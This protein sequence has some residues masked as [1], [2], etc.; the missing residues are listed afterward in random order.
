MIYRRHGRMQVLPNIDR[1]PTGPAGH[2]VVAGLKRLLRKLMLAGCACLA[3]LAPIAPAAETPAPAVNLRQPVLRLPPTARAPVIDGK[4]GEAEWAGAW[5]MEG[6]VGSA[7][8]N[9]EQRKAWAYIAYDREHLYLAIRSATRPGGK[10]HIWEHDPDEALLNMDGV[11][12][13]V[14]APYDPAQPPIDRYQIWFDP[15]GTQWAL[16]HRYGAGFNVREKLNRASSIH[17]D[18]WDIELAFPWRLLG[19]KPEDIKDGRHVLVRPCRNWCGPFLYTSWGGSGGFY[20]MDNMIRVILDSSAPLVRVPSLGDLFAGKAEVKIDV[21][22]ST[23]APVAVKANLVIG[24]YQAAV[25]PAA[26]GAPIASDSRELAVAPGKTRSVTASASF[27]P[28][29][30]LAAKEQH[31]QLRSSYYSVQLDVTRAADGAVLFSRFLKVPGKRDVLW[32]ALPVRD[33]KL[34]GGYYPYFGKV[35]ASLNLGDDPRAKSVTRAVVAVSATNEPGKTLATGQMTAFPY[36]KGETILDVGTLSAGEYVIRADVFARDQ[37]LDFAK[38]LERVFARQSMPWENTQC[39]ITDKVYPPFTPIAVKGSTVSCV[40][41]DHVVGGLGFWNQVVA[42]GE[43]ILAAP[44]GLEG[45][46]NGKKLEWNAPAAPRFIRQAGH[47]TVLEGEASCAALTAKTR[48]LWEYDGMMKVELDLVPAGDGQVDEL[49]LVIP[50]KASVATLMHSTTATRSNPSMEIPAGKG[51]VWDSRRMVQTV[52]KGTFTP[53]IWIGGVERGVCWFADNDRG[54]ITDDRQAAVELQRAGD[55]VNLRVRLINR[56]GVV[57]GPRHIV[58]GLMATPVKPTP[59]ESRAW[60]ND[61]AAARN[62]V[63]HLPSWRFAGF[64]NRE[65]L[66]PLG[67]DFSIFAYFARHQGTGKRPADADA[68]LR[69]WMLRHVKEPERGGLLRDLASG[70]NR[71]VNSDEIV[72]YTNPA[73]EDGSTPQGRQFVNEWRGGINSM[74][75]NFVRSY[76][77]YAAW[78]Y[79]QMLAP[80][81]KCGVYHDNTFPVASTDVIAGSAYVREDGRVQAGWNIFG[82]REFYKRLF[83]AGWQRMGRMPLIYPHTTNGMTIP[84]FSFATIHLALEWEQ[85][86]LRTF[87]EKFKFPLLRTEVM[88]RQA[89]LVPRVLC[90]MEGGGDA[91]TQGY[92]YRTREG[93]LLLHDCYPRGFGPYLGDVVRQLIPLGFHKPSCEFVGYWDKPAQVKTSEGTE[94]SLLKMEKGL[95][96]VVVDTTGKDGVRQVSFDP[97]ALGGQVTDIR[98]FEAD[99]LVRLRADPAV[100]RVYAREYKSYGARWVYFHADRG[101]RKTAANT[102]EFDLRK[103]DYCLLFVPSADAGE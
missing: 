50:V 58:F 32:Q 13:W 101:F 74:G 86:S 2:P 73:L 81:L 95:L 21:A 68:F 12:F 59:S 67:G 92:L 10:L 102:V 87:Q 55:A 56:P 75:C 9:L 91:A 85:G 82:H 71:T 63:S 94:V 26:P 76:N 84:Q 80:G 77:D 93:V 29:E 88:G 61:K 99:A 20:H 96:A 11:E 89:G 31:S 40:L 7:D 4:I 90:H 64:S 43:P 14:A 35:K 36:G 39:G 83:V 78:C 5:M 19:L 30:P 70:F 79:D 98:D 42:K 46:S 66:D 33:V 17:D 69:N 34:G 27:K 103:H 18:V 97:K 23:A 37:K 72:F 60:W 57:K 28:A 6:A 38:P 24:E 16:V 48:C 25:R 47:E 65:T 8:Q 62:F 1:A 3:L 51:V 15:Y 100:Q 45:R 54:W 53:Y 44:M 41:R 49:E 52:G 22:N